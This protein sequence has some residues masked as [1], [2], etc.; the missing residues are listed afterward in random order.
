MKVRRKGWVLA[1]S[2]YFVLWIVTGFVGNR[3]VDAQFDQQFA[4]GTS[5]LNQKEPEGVIRIAR[6]KNLPSAH[7][8]ESDIPTGPW[9][10][11]GQAVAVAP[12][13][14]VDEIAWVT[15][16]L[17]GGA[18]RCLVLWFFGKIWRVPLPA[19]W[20]WNV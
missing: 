14:I 9:R 10:Y 16:P 12:F 20:Y 17:G 4:K 15:A 7:G 19:L 18:G 8:D 11:R 13:L 3:Q 6:P 1:A 2:V 5:R